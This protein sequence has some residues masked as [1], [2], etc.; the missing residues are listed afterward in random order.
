MK[1]AEGKKLNIGDKLWLCIQTDFYFNN[2]YKRL[3]YKPCEREI[4]SMAI[5]PKKIQLYFNPEKKPYNCADSYCDTIYKQNENNTIYC[6]KD[7]ARTYCH[8]QN[9]EYAEKCLED[10]FE[11]RMFYKKIN[12]ELII[13]LRNIGWEK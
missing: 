7:D 11:E 2:T 13:F 10:V 9:Y 4:Y 3:F 5:Y 8:T 6:K 1:Y 12:E